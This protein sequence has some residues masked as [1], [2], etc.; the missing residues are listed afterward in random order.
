MEHYVA[1]VSDLAQNIGYV[2]G[3][4]ADIIEPLLHRMGELIHVFDHNK[5]VFSDK[6]KFLLTELGLQ[7]EME[8]VSE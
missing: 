2:E 3:V 6:T 5:V 4:Q 1:V 7:D 8:Q